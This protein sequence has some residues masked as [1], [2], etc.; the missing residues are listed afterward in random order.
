MSDSDTQTQPTLWAIVPAAGIGRRMDSDI[1]KQYMPL[2]D[3]TVI[4]YTLQK[5]AS[6]EALSGI[7]VVVAE[8]DPYW[9]K[10]H[11]DVAKSITVVT[12]GE[13]RCH[14]VL[15]A[16]THLQAH[17]KPHDWVL[18]HDAARPCVLPGDLRQLVD[19]LRDNEVGGLLGIPVR[20]TMKRADQD[21]FVQQTVEREGL[22]HAL[23]P[24]MFRFHMLYHA[25]VSALDQGQL[26][27]DE[28]AAIELA[29]FS[30]KM[31]EGHSENIKITR[32][33]DLMLAD[34]YL[35]QQIEQ[36]LLGNTAD[37]LEDGG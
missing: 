4:E 37:G 8:D 24:Q 35:Q 36:G 29:G 18:V 22:W 27:T 17:C 10:L 14:S 12:G 1:P 7:I 3:K 31:V 11:V 19:K 9:H 5:L 2:H 30:P 23:T 13:E 25:L 34:F 26:V 33:E 21:G 28:A 20:D 16:L 32:P 6:I 15:N